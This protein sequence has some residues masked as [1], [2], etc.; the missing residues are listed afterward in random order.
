[1]ALVKLLLE[2]P[3]T[4]RVVALE[5]EAGAGAGGRNLKLVY[6]FLPQLVSRDALKATPQNRCLEELAK[7]EF[8]ATD[9]GHFEVVHTQV[10]LELNE[11]LFELLAL[12]FFVLS[13][14][15][16]QLF[17]QSYVCL[18]IHYSIIIK[19]FN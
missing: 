13:V 14:K 2:L 9:L 10:F 17:G 3:E 1:M 11:L 18:V 15:K 12:A 16:L 5:S 6:D 4:A 7:V 8:F 19:L